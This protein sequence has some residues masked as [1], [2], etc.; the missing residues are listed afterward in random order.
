MRK[1]GSTAIA[2]TSVAPVGGHR[3]D[4]DDANITWPGSDDA[5]VELDARTT[6]SI[7]VRL[8]WHSCSGRTWV[9]VTPLGFGER[10]YVEAAPSLART[11]FWHPYAY[12][13]RP[14]ANFG[15]AQA[16]GNR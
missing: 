6:G 16:T 12:R 2:P 8:L 4:D 15:R 1:H 9:E 5:N 13:D 14:T 11:V 10:F 3:V 7:R